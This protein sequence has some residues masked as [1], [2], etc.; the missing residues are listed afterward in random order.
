LYLSKVSS[1]SFRKNTG[2]RISSGSRTVDEPCSRDKDAECPK[3]P[4]IAET[5][6]ILNKTY[7][8]EL[9]LPKLED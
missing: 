4:I 3:R 8:I 1:M 6:T 2:S 5:L 9:S 7:G